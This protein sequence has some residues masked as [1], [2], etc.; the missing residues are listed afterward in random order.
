IPMTGGGLNV[1]R[2]ATCTE[3]IG[4]ESLT[5]KD[6]RCSLTELEQLAAAVSPPVRRREETKQCKVFPPFLS[7]LGENGR[8]RF[9]LVKMRD[10]GR[11][12]IAAV[13]NRGHEVLVVRTTG[14][15]GGHVGIRSLDNFSASEFDSVSC[16]KFSVN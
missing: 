8:P 14:E 13:P 10:N 9:S 16:L 3:C 15:E 7:S 11:L 12:G 2:F 5:E 1:D 6:V 4:F